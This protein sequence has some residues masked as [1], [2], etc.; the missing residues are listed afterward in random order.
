MP[1]SL[2]TPW[3]ITAPLSVVFSWTRYVS[4]VALWNDYARPSTVLWFVI[5]ADAKTIGILK[6]EKTR[7]G[8]GGCA[9]SHGFPP[10]TLF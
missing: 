1:E 6:L 10:C 9:P 7:D 2:E 8:C 4:Q 5:V 3:K